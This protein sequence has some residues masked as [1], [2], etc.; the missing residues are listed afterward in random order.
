MKMDTVVRR[1]WTTQPCVQVLNTAIRAQV[2]GSAIFRT[3]SL[4]V[5]GVNSNGP[6]RL[7]PV[8]S[9]SEQ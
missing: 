9:N 1:G 5:A 6:N 2:D 7:G 4:D 3:V 8:N